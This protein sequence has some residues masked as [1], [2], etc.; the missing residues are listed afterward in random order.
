MS[1]ARIGLVTAA[2]FAAV[3]TSVRALEPTKGMSSATS[4]ETS[5]EQS[6]RTG[7]DSA[8]VAQLL[9]TLE[10]GD[11]LV[12]EIVADQ[13]GNGWWG[14]SSSGIGRFAD[15]RTELQSAR[16]SL[17]GRITHAGTQQML[18]ARLA[19]PNSC[20]RRAA[21]RMLGRSRIET[22]RLVALLDH[23]SPLVRE[24]AA[25]ALGSGEKRVARGPLENML[26]RR[27][28]AEAAM[29]A[30]ALA[31]EDNPES[32]PA[33]ERSLRHSDARVRRASA[34]ALGELALL[35]S[36]T[37]LSEALADRDAEVQ[38]A[39]AR[40]IGELDDL[41]HPP[42]A[43]IAAVKSSDRKLARISALVLADLHDPA[44]LDVLLTLA[45]MDDRDVR[46]QVAEALGEIG[47]IKA[48]PALMR[49]LKDADAD[50][51]RAAAEALGELRENASRD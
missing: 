6:Q 12:C 29:A 42:A 38:Y 14:S 43:L 13:M 8:R 5:A 23:E 30:W 51:R 3:W 46:R 44:T 9:T 10:A 37:P 50:V 21:A 31:E 35:R 4:G 27:G 1:P 22:S 16:D 11:P 24:A 2:V 32:A 19:S 17:S 28:P 47:S 34:Y 41:E 18:I 40:A 20:V 26:A 48:N 39:A 49:L 33:L 15:T 36:L 7:P 25:F 45:D